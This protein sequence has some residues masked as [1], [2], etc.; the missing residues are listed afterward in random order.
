LS[1]RTIP[2]TQIVHQRVKLVTR[3]VVQGRYPGL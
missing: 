1:V 3:A 2:V